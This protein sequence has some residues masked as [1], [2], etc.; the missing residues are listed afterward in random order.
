[1]TIYLDII[2]LENLLMNYIILFGTGL[3]QKEQMKNYKLIISSV[4]GAIY[5]I[6]TYLGIIPIYST[7]LMKVLLSAIMIYIAF[8]IHNVKKMCKTLL[9]FYLVSFATGGLA[10]ALLYLVAPQNIAFNNGVLVGTYPM[11]ITIIAGFLGFC[12]IQYVF[13]INKRMMKTKDLICDLEI[14]M[15][16]KTIQTKAFIDSGNTLKDPITQKAVIIIEKEKIEKALK[17][18]NMEYEQLL[19]NEG[20]QENQDIKFR[21]IPFKS[22]GKQNGMLLGVQAKYVKVIQKG[23]KEIILENVILGLYDKKINKNY[24]ALIGLELLQ[25]DYAEV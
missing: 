15:G 12:I 7:L 17:C 21:L 6:I 11:Q 22:I 2:F 8:D 20:I 14:N 23:E 13:K 24:S 1:M 4:I 3:V 19:K 9:L 10:L 16:E 25:N 5:A 18:R